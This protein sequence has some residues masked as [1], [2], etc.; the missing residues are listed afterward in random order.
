[1]EQSEVPEEAVPAEEFVPTRSEPARDTQDRGYWAV[2]PRTEADGRPDIFF[3]IVK[4]GSPAEQQSLKGDIERALSIC[5][6]IYAS[7][8]STAKRDEA[9]AKLLKLAQVGLVGTDPATAEAAAALLVFKADI[10]NREA[11]RVKNDYMVKLGGW[12]LAFGVVCAILFYIFDRWPWVPAPQ[13]YQYRNFLLILCG[14]MAGAWA[15]FASRKVILSFEDLAA[16]EEDRLE[17]PIR[18]LFAAVLTTI[19]ALIFVTGFGNVVVGGFDASDVLRSGSIATLTGALAGLAEK[20]LP[21]AMM[22][23]ASSFLSGSQNR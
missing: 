12:A 2:E 11:G 20:A 8:D 23:R 1:M 6:S 21:A 19:L 3:K 18:L 9:A 4:P 7:P 13:L 17:P 5:H 22:Q 14:C 10:V 16:L 15:S